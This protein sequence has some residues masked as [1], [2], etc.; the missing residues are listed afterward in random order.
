MYALA[1][2]GV[3]T[4]ALFYGGD[5]GGEV[6]STFFYDGTSFTTRAN[7]AQSQSTDNSGSSGSCLAIGGGS[8][9]VS[10]E[11]YTDGTASPL[12]NI[13]ELTTS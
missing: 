12:L 11:E 13:R 9:A 5:S 6:S 10:V 7:M 2:G 4:S 3:Q 1:A 8:P